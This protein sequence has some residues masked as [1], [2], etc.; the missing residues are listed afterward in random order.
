ME[1]KLTFSAMADGCSKQC[2][3]IAIVNEGQQSFEPYEYFFALLNTSNPQ[4]KLVGPYATVFIE[5]AASG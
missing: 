4:V 3:N 2:V 1:E 5:N